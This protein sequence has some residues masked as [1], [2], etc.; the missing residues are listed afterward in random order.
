MSVRNVL[1]TGSSSGIGLA[2]VCYLL[3]RGHHVWGVSRTKNQF[4]HPRFHP[5]PFDLTKMRTLQ[6]KDLAHFHRIDALVC[7][8]GQG[9]FGHLESLSI[10]QIRN[11]FEINTLSSIYLVKHLLPNL[12][13]RN[14]ADI[15]FVGSQASL[16]GK[17]N[18]SIYCASKFALRGFAQ[19]LRLECASTS[20]RV[21]MI[22]PGMVR[23]PFFET[24]SFEPQP[25]EMHAIDP[26]EIA[27]VVDLILTAPRGVVFD[28][29]ILSPQKHAI[30]KKKPT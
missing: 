26:K 12:K 24:L 4:D 16:E 1:L 25:G 30:R 11:I 27:R 22:Q 14:L 5:C 15:I 7:N 13:K 23:T 10:D 2:T 28:E 3:D 18:G 19:S 8:A 17:K 21:S 29:I 20:V 9:L 6:T